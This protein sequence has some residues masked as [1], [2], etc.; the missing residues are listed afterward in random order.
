MN[1]AVIG[2]G[3][4]E[5]SLCYKLIN[6][7]KIKNLYCIPGNAGTGEICK[8]INIDILNFELLY[9]DLSKNG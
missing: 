5:H 8:N 7:N 1:V 4:R 6:S 2:S 9:K 3:G